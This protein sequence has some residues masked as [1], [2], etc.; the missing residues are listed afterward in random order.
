MEVDNLGPGEEGKEWGRE[1]EADDGI[2]GE[3]KRD[4]SSKVGVGR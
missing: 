1:R 3:R 4:E 2:R